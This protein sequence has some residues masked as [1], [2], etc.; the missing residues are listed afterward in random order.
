MKTEAE[1]DVSTGIGMIGTAGDHQKVGERDSLPLRASRRNRS[2]DTLISDFQ[3][4]RTV[5]E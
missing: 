1:I 2:A 4:P 5:R 3:Q